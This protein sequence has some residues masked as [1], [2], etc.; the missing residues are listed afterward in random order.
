MSLCQ[1]TSSVLFVSPSSLFPSSPLSHF[2]HKSRLHNTR[3]AHQIQP[4]VPLRSRL[5]P[6]YPYPRRIR[7]PTPTTIAPSPPP[8]PLYRIPPFILLSIVPVVWASYSICLKILARLPVALSPPTFNFLRLFVAALS[9]LPALFSALRR[10][11]PNP[12][13]AVLA[14]AELGFY[15]WLV[16]VLQGYGLQ[17]I[18]AS[19]G[20]FLSQLSTVLVPL[21][22]Y[23]SGMEPS[24]P[25]SIIIASILALGGVA[26]LTLDK[27]AG[28]FSLHGDGALLLTA[29]SGAAYILRSKVHMG[30]DKHNSLL[31]LK[32]GTQFVFSAVF[33]LI[34]AVIKGAAKGGGV[35]AELS[36]LFAGTAAPWVIAVNLLIVL[37]AGLI[38]SVLSTDMQIAGQ[39][40][41]QASEAVVFFSLTPLGA[42]LMAL[43]LGERF[44]PKGLVGGALVL[45][46]AVIAALNSTKKKQ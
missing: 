45:A 28:A 1:T 29:V 12:M 11:K 30:R 21:A 20:A 33:F 44:G 26:C 46:S 10:L 17:F 42:S 27:V 3:P 24:L 19:R 7:S 23:L 40:R 14:G 16:N 15:T 25:F 22:A 32:V 18:P 39:T 6:S 8:S 34:T 43:P 13:P 9:I 41:V 38:I 2:S 31:P 5:H 36:A 35:M 4:R 37:W